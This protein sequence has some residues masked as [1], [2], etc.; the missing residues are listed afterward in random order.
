MIQL[1][2]YNIIICDLYESKVILGNHII[3]ILIWKHIF[4]LY[5]E[6]KM[7]QITL[8][9]WY[10]KIF[11]PYM[12]GKGLKLKYLK[13]NSDTESVILYWIMIENMCFNVREK[14]GISINNMKISIT[15]RLNGNGHKD[16]A[17]VAI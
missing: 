8:Q 3:R 5:N 14:S 11:K 9:L 13:T 10:D 7:L 4:N 17:G 1:G 2:L 12:H 6:F 16:D 15:T